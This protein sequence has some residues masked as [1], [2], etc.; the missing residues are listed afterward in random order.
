MYSR[1]MPYCVAYY[2]STF[3]AGAH[4]P[5]TETRSH[6]ARSRLLGLSRASQPSWEGASRPQ[7]WGT[8]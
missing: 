6:P 7:G 4:R 2:Y 1:S 3:L 5:I 8:S